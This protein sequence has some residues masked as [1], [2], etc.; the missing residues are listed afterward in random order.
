MITNKYPKLYYY[1]Y[2]ARFS[3]K[4]NTVYKTIKRSIDH[5]SINDSE[6]SE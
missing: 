3:E 5:L 2:F 6:F 1:V 4:C